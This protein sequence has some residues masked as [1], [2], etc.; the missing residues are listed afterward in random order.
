MRLTRLA[1]TLLGA[2]LVVAVS[3]S[4][5]L[6][7]SD[8]PAANATASWTNTDVTAISAGNDHTCAIESGKVFCW[9]RVVAGLLG[10]GI[11]NDLQGATQSTALLVSSVTGGFPNQNVAAISSG[12]QHSCAIEAGSVY[13]WGSN[14]TGQLGHEPSVNSTRSPESCV[15]QFQTYACSSK[16]IKVRASADNSFTNSNVTA[17][18]AGS[19]HTCAIE[20]G[21][22][23]CWGKNGNGGF[24]SPDVGRLGNNSTTQSTLPI[25]VSNVTGGFTNTNVTSVAAAAAHTCA[26]QGGMTYCWGQN[27]LSGSA[28]SLPHLGGQLG[29]GS[30]GTTF[31][32]T[33]PGPGSSVAALVVDG[34]FASGNTSVSGVW[35]RSGHSCAIKAGVTYCWGAGQAGSLASQGGGGLGTG[36]IASEGSPKKVVDKLTV[37]G[38]SLNN[39]GS[40]ISLSAGAWHT[41]AI[42][43]SSGSATSGVAHCWGANKS[44]Q[45]GIGTSSDSYVPVAVSS[46]TAQ[47]GFTNT[48][49]SAITAGRDHT[50]AIEAKVA[51]CWG[52]DTYRKLGN[53]QAAVIRNKPLKV[54]IAPAVPAAPTIQSIDERD[55]YLDVNFIPASDG[56]SPLTNYEYSIDGGAFVARN[57]ASVYGP[58]KIESL[59]NGQQYTIKIRAVNAI[60]SGAESAAETGTPRAPWTP[61]SGGGS[62]GGGSTGGGSTGGGSTGGGSTGGGSTGGDNSNTE[63]TT[64]SSSTSVASTTTA[65]GD[66]FTNAVPGVTVT[67]TRVYQQAPAEVAGNSAIIVLTSAQNKVMD[68]ETKTPSV[69]LPNDDELVFIDEGRCIADVVNA[70]TRKVL[71]TLRT[72]VVEDEVSELKVGNEIVTLAPIYFDVM[73]STLDT[74]AMSRVKSLKARVSAAGSVLLVGHSGT[75]NGNSPENIAISRARAESTLKALRSVGAKGPFAVNGVGAFDPARTAKTE[76][77]QAKNRRVVIVLIP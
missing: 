18:S 61:P 25:A 45:L 66:V 46:S 19:D 70:K 6:P 39:N 8:V 35:S 12:G 44:A 73:S 27:W 53:G 65:P 20:G 58:I 21:K 32:S 75:L 22:L 5:G 62:T 50:C 55:G 57:P 14:E 72:T 34:D 16:P 71:R 51:Y 15:G 67:D 13:C 48:A 33:P 69:C 41:C 74:K 59:T 64:A 9:G 4:I 23:F 76:A 1:R 40:V 68:V 54:A 31:S 17:V 43:G 11:T 60:G 24:T 28:A 42:E 7:A 2:L 63:A 77:A 30:I 56:G 36:S 38:S 52:D 3:I 49:V 26:I 47:P 29:I 37:S 10:T